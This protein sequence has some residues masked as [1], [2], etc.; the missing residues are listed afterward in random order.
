MRKST[1]F[2]TSIFCLFFAGYLYAADSYVLLDLG[3]MGNDW[4][5]AN[6]I[7]NH[8]VVVG[9]TG[10]SG[11]KWEPLRKPDISTGTP[12]GRVTILPFWPPDSTVPLEI[13]AESIND[14]NEIIGSGVLID[15]FFWPPY[16]L[17]WDSDANPEHLF[18]NGPG[19]DINNSSHAIVHDNI[20]EEP[21]L[22]NE[23][24]W[25]SIIDIGDQSY[26]NAMNNTDQ[27]V[28]WIVERDDDGY[29]G[30]QY[31]YLW[32]RGSIIDL[33]VFNPDPS[34]M[35]LTSAVDINHFGQIIGE[36][37]ISRPD[38]SFAYSSFLVSGGQVRDLGFEDARAVNDKGA[39]VGSHYLYKSFQTVDRSGNLHIFRGRLY[40]L[41]KLIK[42]KYR[43][44]CGTS[45][46][47]DKSLCRLQKIKYK[48][49]EARDINNSGQIVGSAIIDGA[50]HAVLL[51]PFKAGRL[52]FPD[53]PTSLEVVSD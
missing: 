28:G 10:V 21:M 20:F 52:T 3:T 26:A 13:S 43:W 9:N 12:L 48:Y 7:N 2:F 45:L 25:T 24:G 40:D 31:A 49:L 46:L 37:D 42:Y 29:V 38:G 6:S 39:V 18:G 50:E 41:D 22:L 5:C 51:L 11:F 34:T 53:D 19:V 36:L 16:A 14:N 35:N 15:P 8:G 27:V 44:S 4:S 32:Q 17:V 23:S 33:N 47:P 1:T 30:Y